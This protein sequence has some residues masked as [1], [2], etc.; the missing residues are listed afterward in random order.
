MSSSLIPV[1]LNMIQGGGLE[2]ERAGDCG[3]PEGAVGAEEGVRGEG[4][5]RPEEHGGAAEDAAGG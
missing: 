4:G 1:V 2:E 3:G 5:E